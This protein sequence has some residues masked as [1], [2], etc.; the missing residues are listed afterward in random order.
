MAEPIRAPEQVPRG[1]G[2]VARGLEALV[3]LGFE[4]TV[5][6]EVRTELVR[7]DA[8]TMRVTSTRPAMGT[9]V[10]VAAIG[11]S[12]HRA[13][14]AIGRAFEE[15]DRL[16]GL[17][18]RH[19][20]SSPLAHLNRTGR[21]DGPPPELAHVV[22]Q[23]LAYH[24]LT[25][26]A[27]DVTVAPLV[28]L[29]E[30]RAEADSPSL[31]SER[32]VR[33]ALEHVGAGFVSFS[34]RRIGFA[35]QGMALT[36]D[37]IAKGYIVDRIAH[38]LE[39]HGVERY[40][41]DA[42]GDIRSRGTKEGGAPWTI[43]VKDPSH[44]A[45]FLDSIRL[46]AGAVATSGGYERAYDAARLHHHVFDARSGRSPTR[47]V[48]ASVVAPTTMAADALATSLLLM[49]PREAVA[50]VDGERGCACLIMD[51]EGRAVRSR[52]WRSAAPPEGDEAQ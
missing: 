48:S 3:D 52:A 37:G 32:E 21:L 15:M 38:A 49:N 29:Y 26:G 23:A 7:A 33:E 18:S 36:L 5:V 17:L 14:E 19:E 45:G 30:S 25:G 34:T 27:F 11:P 24:R 28:F 39:Q 9:R 41:V 44:R 2:R 42:G 50:F 13:V 35:R 46:T 8:R 43:A 10:T 22:E 31:P 16:V 51:R 4:R 20:P 12:E 40:L 6:P 47:I 1:A